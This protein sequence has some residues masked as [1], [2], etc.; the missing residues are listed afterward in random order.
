MPI[1][2]EAVLLSLATATGMGGAW[3]ISWANS[4]DT[5]ILGDFFDMA[6]QE[7]IQITDCVT[8]LHHC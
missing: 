1:N 3:R 4:M 2:N 7:P 5:G 6:E 8:L